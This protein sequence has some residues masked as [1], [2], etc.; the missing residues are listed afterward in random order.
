MFLV[1]VGGEPKDTFFKNMLFPLSEDPCSFRIWEECFMELISDCSTARFNNGFFS[2]PFPVGALKMFE[3]PAG[4]RHVQ[5]EEM[6]P[7]PH[8][9]GKS[10]TWS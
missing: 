10:Q 1:A 7:S 3:I 8:T 4:A 5:I 6:E 9:I 2:L